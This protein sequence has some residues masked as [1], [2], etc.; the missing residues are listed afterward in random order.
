MQDTERRWRRR[1]SSKGSVVVLGLGRFGRAFA[2]EAVALG[3]D[4]VAADSNAELVAAL[5]EDIPGCTQA[6][7]TAERA[8]ESLGVAEAD[9]V[10]V[11]TGSDVETSV[12]AV[13][14]LVALDA[15][16][17]WA[18]ACSDRHR[19]AL[20]KIGAHRVIQPET[21][22]GLRLAHQV[23]VGT[24]E[25]VPLDEHFD[26]IECEAGPRL[27]GRTVADLDLR[28]TFDVNL[29]AI[30]HAGGR[31]RHVSGDDRLV[32]G[33]LILLAGATDATERFRAAY[34]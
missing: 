24:H 19:E 12:L 11:A 31:F 20:V 17:I 6:D 16:R 21:S 26:L 7:I 14:T 29:V 30:K 22:E 10:L 25:Y 4:V 23:R 13:A 9:V 18:K 3:H 33:D 34:G 5:A 1:P 8:L 32:E 2:R 27:A 15:P 28:A